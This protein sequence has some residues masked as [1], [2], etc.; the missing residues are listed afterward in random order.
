MTRKEIEKILRAIAVQRGLELRFPLPVFGTK[1][2]GAR[3]QYLAGSCG[4]LVPKATFSVSEGDDDS[5][6]RAKAATAADALHMKI[7][8]GWNKIDSVPVLDMKNEAA[9]KLG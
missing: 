4:N 9:E 1:D 5:T 8:V 2:Y 6:V 7:L 3:Y